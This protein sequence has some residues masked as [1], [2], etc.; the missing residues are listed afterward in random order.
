[1]YTN[2]SHS[3]VRKRSCGGFTLT[4]VMVASTILML[5]LGGFLASFIVGLRTLD[6][7]TN[8]YRATAIARNRIQ[9]ARSFDYDSLTLL[10]ENE[11]PIDRHGN[12]DSSGTFRR[13]TD[14]FTNTVTAPHTVRIQVG[15]R[16][17]VR[18]KAGLSEPLVMENLIAVR[19]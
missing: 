13:S 18:S 7:T 4:E 11:V 2:T 3:A 5:F 9:R 14:I 19:M 1:M 17:P 6:M 16:F 15:V 8:H 10:I 12:A